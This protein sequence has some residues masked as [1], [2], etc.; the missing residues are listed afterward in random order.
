MHIVRRWHDPGPIEAVRSR[1]D[2][3]AAQLAA[4][5]TLVFRFARPLPLG[6]VRRHVEGVVAGTRPFALDLHGVTVTPENDVDLDVREGAAE[7]VALR[8]RLYGGLL[9]PWLDAARPFVARSRSA[10]PAMAPAC[11]MPCAPPA[12]GWPDPARR[13]ER[14]QRFV[15][16]LH[17][18]ADAV[19]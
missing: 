3:L 16:P 8:D 7:V 5:A 14:R 13:G 11:P 1:W 10:A 4:H 6:R 2:P 17:Q 9:G 12:P 18:G 15:C 19:P